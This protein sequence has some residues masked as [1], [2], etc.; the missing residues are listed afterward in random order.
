[1]RK[2]WTKI[3]VILMAV[4]LLCGMPE[5]DVLAQGA[6]NGTVAVASALVPAS[7]IKLNKTSIAI[8]E[9]KKYT[10]TAKLTPSNSNDSVTWISSNT[11]VA[12]V[13]KR[14]VVK[15][16]SKGTATISA[17][18]TGGLQQ[19]CKVTVKRP[20]INTK[21]KTLVLNQTFT[22][23]LTGA[24]AATF[25]SSN[26]KVATVSNKGKVKAKSVGRTTITVKDKNGKKYT[27]NVKVKNDP[28]S[29]EQ[30]YAKMIALKKKYPE[31]MPWTNADFYA[32]KGGIYSGGYGCAGFAFILSDAAFGDLPARTHKNFSKIKVGDILRINNDT[33]SVIVL[34]V[35]ASSVIVAEGNY[36]SSIHWGREISLSDI[37]KTGTYVMTRYPEK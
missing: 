14:G 21:N 26:P 29:A 3:I 28:Y 31:G 17:K 20:T 24:T 7:K 15:A 16:V 35:R 11:K 19:K 34:E 33:H 36:N 27:C 12:T 32:W 4:C 10:L 6:N 22:L 8:Y 13:S 25:K 37:R 30:V 2:M 18:T 5:A 1:M 9:G 23:K